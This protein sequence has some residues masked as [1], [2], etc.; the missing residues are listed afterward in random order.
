MMFSNVFKKPYFRYI[1]Q[2]NVQLVYCKALWDILPLTPSREALVKP[3]GELTQSV[4]L[5]VRR[6]DAA[7]ICQ[8]GGVSH[9]SS[10]GQIQAK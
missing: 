4:P 10:R 8:A 3:L 1:G 9:T 5:S 7:Q 6:A 2:S